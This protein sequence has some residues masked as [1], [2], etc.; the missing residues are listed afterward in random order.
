[1]K[2]LRILIVLVVIIGIIFAGV[3]L[4]IKKTPNF[5]LPFVSKLQPQVGQSEEAKKLQSILTPTALPLSVKN[6]KLSISKNA[7]EKGNTVYVI[8]GQLLSDVSEKDGYF[9]ADFAVDGDASK[10]PIKLLLSTKDSTFQFGTKNAKGDLEWKLEKA[11][12]VFAALKAGIKV[13]LREVLDRTNPELVKNLEAPIEEL[14]NT[15]QIKP[16]TYSI[17]P[18]MIGIL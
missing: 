16:N 7:M 9:F 15:T 8:Q 18:Q 10:T 13:E 17:Q 5:T 2:L 11:P 3:F 4:L 14:A 1:M 6:S 12:I